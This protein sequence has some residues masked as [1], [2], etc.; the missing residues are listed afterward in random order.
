M[1]SRVF[2]DPFIDGGAVLRI[3]TPTVTIHNDNF[4]R[5][6]TAEGAGIGSPVVGNAYSLVDGTN[7]ASSLGRILSNAFTVDAAGTVYAVSQYTAA[8]IPTLIRLKAKFLNQGVF[9]GSAESGFKS[10]IRRRT[11]RSLSFCCRHSTEAVRS[12]S[13]PPSCPL[14]SLS[15]WIRSMFLSYASL[16]TAR[17]LC[18]LSMARF[19]QP[20]PS[21]VL[22]LS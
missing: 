6:D 7:V 15:T 14:C 12:Q 19:T 8:S 1:S 22:R 16:W 5:T 2:A 4:T 3:P 13:I 20:S 18:C 11:T 17:Q 21:R 10:S 9:W